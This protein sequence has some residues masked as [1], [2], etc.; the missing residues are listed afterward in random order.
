MAWAGTAARSGRRRVKVGDS[1]LGL[2][3]LFWGQYDVVSGR[4][5]CLSGTATTLDIVELYTHLSNS[6]P[7]L[8]P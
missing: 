7:T 8:S 2:F 1:I 4:M 6:T 5:F 3:R